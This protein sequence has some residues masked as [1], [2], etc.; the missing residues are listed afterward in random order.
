MLSD[1]S[2][3]NK[4]SEHPSPARIFEQYFKVVPALTTPL[5]QKTYQIRHEVYCR[6]LGW[7]PSRTDGKESDKYDSHSIPCLLTTAQTGASVGSLRLVLNSQTLAEDAFPVVVACKSTIDKDLLA[8]VLSNRSKVAEVSR[9]AVMRDYR[10]RKG[11]TEKP[12]VISDSDF[13]DHEHKRFPYI[14]VS[15]FLSALAM[16]ENLDIQYLLLLSEPRLAQHLGRLGFVI[17]Q[18]GAEIEHRGTRI[19]SVI[20]T[21]STIENFRNPLPNIWSV[22][23]REIEEGFVQDAQSPLQYG[24]G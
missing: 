12:I 8:A 10:R 18:I 19:P 6:D 20:E 3:E 14:P 24:Y 23:S 13:G 17:Q 4:A 2:T 5:I 16:A 21:K 22:V 15:L 1:E 7:E 9:L 11:E